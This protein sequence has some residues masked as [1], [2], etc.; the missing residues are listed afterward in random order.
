MKLWIRKI[1]V[2]LIT[3]MTLGVYIPPTYLNVNAEESSETVSSEV[4]VIT[5][6]AEINKEEDSS[7]AEADDGD[8]ISLLTEQ[9]KQQTLTKLGPKIFNQVEDDF[10]NTIL[11]NMET[12][13]NQILEEAGEKTSYLAITEMPAN[14]YGEKIFNI[15]DY[16]T[17]KDIARFDVRRDKRPLEGYWFN[18]HYHVSSD[19]FEEHHNIG[20]VY[21]DKNIPPKWMA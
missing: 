2:I 6:V 21:W 5:P 7:E 16:Q 14:G 1:S 10:T 19:D 12:V 3:F 17:K 20:D 4:D 15:Y 18:F 13:L 9:A 8:I 11:P